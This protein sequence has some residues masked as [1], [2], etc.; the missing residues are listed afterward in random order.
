M[1]FTQPLKLVV[2]AGRIRPNDKRRLVYLTT[3]TSFDLNL[4]IARQTSYLDRRSSRWIA[5]ELRL[6][7]LIQFVVS[8]S[9][10][11]GTLLPSICVLSYCLQQSRTAVRVLENLLELSLETLRHLTRFRIKSDLSRSENQIPGNY[12]RRKVR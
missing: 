3:A 9:C 12:R 11:P 7:K 2:E 6:I 4:R 8:R 10:R 1:T 5:L